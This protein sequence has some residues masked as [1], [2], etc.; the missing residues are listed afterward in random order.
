[1]LVDSHAHLNFQAF[2]EDRS[3][4]IARCKN[5]GMLVVNVGAAKATSQ[6]ALEIADGQNFY[7]SLGLHPIHVFDEE[8]KVNDYQKL[9][10]E[11]KD[12]VVAM[13]E[14]GFDYF[15]L[16]MS[17][18]KGAKSVAE[19]KDKQKKV[20]LQHLELAKKNNLAVIVHGR[21]GKPASPQGGDEPS[22]Y[23]DI[24]E[25]LKESGQKRGVV[26]CFGGNLEEAKLVVEMGFYIGITGIITFDKTGVLEEIIS[27]VPL[28]RILI[29]T[30]SPYLAPEPY[31]GKRNEPLYV[32]Y[33]AEKIAQVKGKSVEDIIEI[34]GNNAKS[35]FNLS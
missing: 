1:M 9:I 2:N 31:R 34:T 17:F 32:Q 33:V 20:F 3:Q 35:L 24:Y 28:E 21:N 10:D 15:H 4:V 29:E 26:H 11:N 14:T 27:E 8:F 22:A 30:D 25:L 5:A 19:I 18:A 12:R 13:G 23:R 7:A 16:D 6:K